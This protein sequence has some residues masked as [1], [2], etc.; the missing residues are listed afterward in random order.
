M[1]VSIE[2]LCL[3]TFVREVIKK[4]KSSMEKLE[5]LQ[6]TVCDEKIAWQIFEE[7]ITALRGSVPASDVLSA[8]LAK[9]GKLLRA[10]CAEF[11]SLKE[12]MARVNTEKADFDE[13][14]D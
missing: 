8:K 3:V 4:K 7:K 13:L 12:Q 6:K 14:L 5:A 1:T 2:S 10:V 9:S 11:T